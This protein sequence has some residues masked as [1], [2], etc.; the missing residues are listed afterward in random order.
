MWNIR[1]WVCDDKLFGSPK[2]SD[3]SF[4]VISIVQL[5]LAG[6]WEGTVLVL[7]DGRNIRNVNY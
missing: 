6:L 5:Q 2:L 4:K 7:I 3:H 1:D